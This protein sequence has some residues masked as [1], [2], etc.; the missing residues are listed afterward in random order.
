VSW[1]AFTVGVDV[2]HGEAHLELDLSK[3]PSFPSSFRAR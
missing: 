1:G 3:D 2:N